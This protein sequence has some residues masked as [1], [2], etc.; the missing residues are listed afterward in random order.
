MKSS[1]GI[2]SQNNIG[3]VL[4]ILATAAI[5]LPRTLDMSYSV[6]L[7]F[8]SMYAPLIILWG[9][10]KARFTWEEIQNQ[11]SAWLSTFYPWPCF[12]SMFCPA[13]E[14]SL[15]PTLRKI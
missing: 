11:G 9:Y 3:L 4:I 14:F 15:S 12:C 1:H 13:W 6:K 2:F 8:Y 7:L 5:L 10:N